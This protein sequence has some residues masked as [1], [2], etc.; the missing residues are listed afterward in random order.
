M[1]NLIQVIQ[2]VSGLNEIEARIVAYYLGASYKLSEFNWF[3]TLQITGPIG[4][5]KSCILDICR[6][7]AF[8]VRSILCHENMT[9]AVLRDEL[10]MAADGTA[11]VEEAD[12]FPNRKQL[13]NYLINRVD[14]IRTSGITVKEQ[15][16][17]GQAVGWQNV[18]RQI[19][20]ATI[21]HDRHS[22]S[23]LAIESRAIVI[24]TKKVF[25]RTF[26]TTTPTG[27]TMPSFNLA[28]APANLPCGR[29]TDTWMP[30]VRV[31]AG[32]GDTDFPDYAL[33]QIKAA[34]KALADG[35][36]FEEK[37]SIFAQV[38]SGYE[39]YTNN[40]VSGFGL[41]AIRETDG[42]PLQQYVLEPLRKEMPYTT[43]H[44]VAKVLTSMGLTVKRQGGRLKL[45]TT[46]EKL[47]VVAAAI[48]YED[49]ALA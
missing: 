13:Q 7:V 40:V 12:L 25:G 43:P 30:L 42:L 20:G 14:R 6:Q 39:D 49:E 8:K 16:Q 35:H 27:L 9:S 15:F 24:C 22:F 23:D 38:V 10:I 46:L 47:K 28:S 21:I 26:P 45:F 48:G 44:L 1:R 29:A 3:P 11:I 34:D 33:T 17:T 32:L 2:A 37:Q 18:T 41:A 31:A 36:V 4:T 5:G 19:F